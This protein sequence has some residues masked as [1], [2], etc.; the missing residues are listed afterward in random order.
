[1]T[2][3]GQLFEILKLRSMI[4]DAEKGG[5]R[6]AGEH[7]DRITPVGRII[8]AIRFD[9]LPHMA[10]KESQKQCA[11]V[12][13]VNISICHYYKLAVTSLAQIKIITYACAH[14]RDH[15]PNFLIL[16]NLVKTSLFHIDDF[17][18]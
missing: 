18:A 17:T 8:R 12:S 15:R 14:R 2:K 11:Y 1:M 5:A 6:L 16:Q 4:V 3:D 10:E 13:T 7:D 9:E